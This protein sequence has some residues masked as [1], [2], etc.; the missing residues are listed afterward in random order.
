ML[1]IEKIDKLEDFLKLEK[2]WNDLLAQSDS[3]LPFFTFELISL[4]W[5]VFGIKNEL[6]VLLIKEN[7]ELIAIAPL[8]SSKTKWRGL[9]VK[10]VTFIGDHYS[11]RLGLIIKNNAINKEDIFQHIVAYLK[12]TKH[13]FDLISLDLIV[14]NS[15]T[16]LTIKKFLDA[17][18][19]KHRRM[20]TDL[21]PYLLINSD[22]DSYLKTRSANFRSKLKRTRNGFNKEHNF[23]ITKYENSDVLNG[24]K[25]LLTISKET[26]KYKNGTAIASK[27]NS[28][29][30][31]THLA[32]QTSKSGWLNLWI[33]KL[34]TIPIS[35]V[36]NLSY[37]MK[38]YFL[39]VGFDEAYKK[40]SP[41]L[42]L[43][44]RTVFEAFANGHKEFDFLGANEDYK[45]KWTS[46]CRQHCKYFIFN[47]NPYGRL[48][49]QLELKLVLKSKMMLKNS[50]SILFAF[51]KRSHEN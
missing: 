1:T 21:S 11:N 10:A 41:G 47:S 5:Q 17:N 18:A 27:K 48:L 51:K 26:W 45:L 30:F 15:D 31:F 16:D 24:M 38:I 14:D 6:L 43:T 42:F 34:N 49:S 36:F 9:T 40:I 20:K 23:Q 12:S 25:E 7:N 13:E 29:I 50:A 19:M 35:F 22:W 2:S 32:E 8:Q 44:E 46:L 4:W 33:L 3:D 37:K 28:V 39:K